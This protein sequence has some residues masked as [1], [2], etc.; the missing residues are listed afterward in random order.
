MRN[1]RQSFGQSFGQ[2]LG[3]VERWMSIL[4][5]LGLTLAAL[6]GGGILRRAAAGAAGASLLSRGVTGYCGMKAAVTGQASL[7][8][9]LMEQVSRTRFGLSPPD[10][11]DSLESLYLAELQELRSAEHQL[12]TLV[13][14]VA[15]NFEAPELNRILRGYATE[16]RSR[17][18]DLDRILASRGVNPRRHPDQ[19]MQALANETRKMERVC[20]PGVREAALIASLQRI[21]HYKIAGYG[22]VAAYAKSLGLTEDAARFA[23]HADREKAVDSELTDFAK[24]IVNPLARAEPQAHARFEART[25]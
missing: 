15:G 13:D 24:T 4:A 17:R 7:R 11:I 25:H 10:Q 9:G 8:E 12:A 14:E 20:A 23:D 16:I 21:I 18:D 6:R 5:G 22:N 2:N 19:G 3:D 1:S